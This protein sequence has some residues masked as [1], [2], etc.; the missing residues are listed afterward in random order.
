MNP[1]TQYL[2]EEKKHE[3]VLHFVCGAL[4]RRNAFAG[5]CPG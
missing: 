5:M 4:D 2:N 3:E 1:N